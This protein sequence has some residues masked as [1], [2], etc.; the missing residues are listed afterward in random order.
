MGL[1]VTQTNAPA[2]KVST[3]SNSSGTLAVNGGNAAISGPIQGSGYQPQPAVNPQTQYSSISRYS[4]VNVYSA[5]NTGGW[6]NNNYDPYAAQARAAAQAAA[7]AEAQKR[8]QDLERFNIGKN[9]ALQSA[10]DSI[11]QWN[12]DKAFD[13][14]KWLSNYKLSTDKLN[15]SAINFEAGKKTSYG[16]INDMINQGIRSAG[17]MLAGRNASD[18]S[19]AAAI[20]QAYGDYGT[21][22]A[23]GVEQQYRQDMQGLDFEAAALAEN[24]RLYEQELQQSKAAQTDKIISDARNALA[25]LNEAAVGA[26]LADRIDIEQTKEQI[27][28]QAT[29]ELAGLDSKLSGGAAGIQR[30]NKPDT[31]SRAN[32]QLQ[33]GQL[34]KQYN[35]S[36]AAPIGQASSQVMSSQLPI[37]SNLRAKKEF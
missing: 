33:G 3:G 17:T 2:L 9:N 7:Q 32:Q 4:P 6:S 20:A 31:L 26:G 29:R 36:T 1:Q 8:A 5:Q 14:E 15:Q 13:I 34:G 37:Y 11:G 30:L 18:S 28:Q 21:S 22:Q 16:G 23:K 19:A 10:T 27:R 35:F 12:R 25:S 24:K